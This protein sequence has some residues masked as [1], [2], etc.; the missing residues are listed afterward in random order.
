MNN[1]ERITTSSSLSGLWNL[2]FFFYLSNIPTYV[3]LF[4]HPYIFTKIKIPMYIPSTTENNRCN[5]EGQS[6]FYPL[7]TLT[8]TLPTTLAT[9]LTKF[10]VRYGGNLS[11]TTSNE[12][13][14]INFY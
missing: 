8:K 12:L 5:K 4:M 14:N 10:R 7:T 6:S 1:K 3:C 11:A 9:I 2:G 13:K